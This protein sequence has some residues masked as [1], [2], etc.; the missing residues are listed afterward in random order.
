MTWHIPKTWT[1][2]P[3]TS[4]DLNAQLRDNLGFLKDPPTVFGRTA[5]LSGVGSVTTTSLTWVAIHASLSLSITTAGGDLWLWC[6]GR[7]NNQTSGTIQIY[8]D[9]ELDGTR[10]DGGTAGCAGGPGI[11]HTIPITTLARGVAPGLHVVKPV[12]RVESA[13][14]AWWNMNGVFWIREV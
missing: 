12:W 7:V 14:T 9:F 4:G 3:L 2:E 5:T 13:S 1:A 10:V 11:N 8:L 6:T